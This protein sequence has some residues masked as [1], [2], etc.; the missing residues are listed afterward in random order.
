MTASEEEID[1]FSLSVSIVLYKTETIEIEKLIFAFLAQGA[2]Q[3]FVIDNSPVAFDTFHPL[4]PSLQSDRVV[5]IRTG[6]NLG[7]GRAHNIAIGAAAGR[8]KYHIIC[9][10]DIILSSDVLRTLLDYMNG[11]P[12]V[13]LCMPRLVGTDGE[14]QHCCRRS[15]VIWDYA[16]Q[17]FFPNTRGRRRKHLLE[18]R[19]CNYREEMDVECL[20]G[21]FMVFRMSVL[22]KIG[23]FDK[24]FFMY[25]E[26]FDISMRS[27]QVA[28]NV[29]VP[30]TYVVHERRSAHRRSWRLRLEFGVS[31]LKYFFKWGVFSRRLLANKRSR[32]AIS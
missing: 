22:Q 13:G 10:P 20:S 23:G 1:E 4:T 25:F 17:L 7:Y 31:A 29:Y 5:P 14:E 28:R 19:D 3:I 9:N 27:G 18:M 24:R 30:G 32:K 2:S 16:S 8:F 11:H 15:P 21:C 12:D 26:D 6:K